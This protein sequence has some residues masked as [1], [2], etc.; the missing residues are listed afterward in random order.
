MAK[1]TTTKRPVGELPEELALRKL[2]ARAEAQMLR[3]AMKHT[4]AQLS[5]YAAAKVSR[6]TK[7]WRSPLSSADA[8]ILEDATRLNAR[9]RQLVRDSWIAK[10]AVRAKSRNVV[11]CGIIPVPAAH[12][13]GTEL[14]DH[15]QTL[16]SLFWD[17][18]SD[19][20]ACD[21]EGRLSFWQ[22]QT[23][24]VED[25]FVVGE[26]FFVWSYT[27]NKQFVGLQLQSFEPEQLNVDIQNY[28]A[29]EVRRGIEVDAIGK[30]VAYHFYERT[31]NDYLT[32]KTRTIRIPAA[33]VFH[34]FKADR[35][36]QSH[37]VSDLAPVMMDIRDFTSFKD[38][39][40]FRAKMEACIGFVITK[41][42]S[43]GL[44]IAPGISPGAGESTNLSGGERAIDMAPGMVPELNP[45]E[46]VTP[47][48]PS[49][50][51]NSYEPFTEV[52]VR[53]IGAGVG[54]SYG[55]LAR[56]SDGNYS[57]ARQDMLEDEREL[58]PEQDMTVD[59]LVK[60]IFE[61]FVSF[62]VAE[63]RTAISPEE[64]AANRRRYVEAEYITPG[65][66]WID[67]EKEA[68]AA[69]K[70]L[71]LRLQTRKELRGKMGGRYPRTLHQIADEKKQAAVYGITF[72]EDQE[73]QGVVAG[74][75][76][77]ALPGPTSTPADSGTVNTEVKAD[78]S[79]NGAQITAVLDVFGRLAR[80]EITPDVAIELLVA[81]GLPRD[82]AGEMV[83]DQATVKPPA[84]PTPQPAAQSRLAVIEAPN[85]QASTSDA[86]RCG[87][88][89]YLNGSRC[90]AYDSTVSTAFVCDA[91]EAP[92]VT[93]ATATASRFNQPPGPPDGE[94]PF[95]E[96]SARDEV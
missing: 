80:K 40:L 20:N 3:A 5:T 49:S 23:R 86:M 11:G 4:K 66:P 64:F 21:V 28:G 89:R 42:Q 87:T 17:W 94:K 27:P 96:T 26:H 48:V 47:F 39:M 2:R 67:P 22:M 51:G 63:M 9:A 36:Q 77:P 56:K 14:T 74:K 35:A 85:Y 34:Y 8:V 52:T 54:L 25:R 68:N 10:S 71:K 29:H 16:E 92:P 75:A 91:W 19:R 55:A 38:A 53:G 24:A 88:C 84:E 76:Q 93:E 82:R 30:A 60:P 44:G 37:G 95:D 7:D 61:L 73:Q 18:A 90:I 15:N 45:G 50:P 6:Q 57:A 72:P 41:T 70:M 59:T 83:A 58:G 78:S 62:A 79:P 81:V 31:P 13:N 46:T 33:R 12:I 65:R 69:E 43:T 32:S 1:R